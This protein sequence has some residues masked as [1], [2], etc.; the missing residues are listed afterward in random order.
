[1][2]AGGN[3]TS[4]LAVEVSSRLTDATGDV[5]DPAISNELEHATRLANDQISQRNDN[6]A[7][8]A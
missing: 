7:A 2:D 5:L 4:N 3:I 6:G 1:V 8:A